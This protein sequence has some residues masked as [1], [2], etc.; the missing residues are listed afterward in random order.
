MKME[1]CSEKSAHKIQ[2]TGITQK[3]EY[4]IQ[5]MGTFWNQE[6]VLVASSKNLKVPVITQ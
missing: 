2:K 4:Y 3:K 1:Q 5:N 6:Y